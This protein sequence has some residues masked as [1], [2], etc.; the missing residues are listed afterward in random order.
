MKEEKK[1]ESEDKKE[2]AKAGEEPTTVTAGGPAEAAAVAVTAA[3]GKFLF[4]FAKRRTQLTWFS[5]RYRWHC[6]QERE[7]RR[8][9]RHH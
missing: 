7:P 2:E 4:N 6:R 3:T 1:A 8:G 5:S 9:H